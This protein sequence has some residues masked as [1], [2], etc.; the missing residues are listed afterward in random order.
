MKNHQLNSRKSC[1]DSIRL[2]L[3]RCSF[4]CRFDF[5]LASNY[6][7]YCCGLIRHVTCDST[8]AQ[9]ART[10]HAAKTCAPTIRTWSSTTAS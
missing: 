8:C 1:F 2:N 4:N 10:I 9:R 3:A 5:G 6:S 7:A